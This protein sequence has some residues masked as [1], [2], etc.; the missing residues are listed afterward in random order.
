M[1]DM[2]T[3][4]TNTCGRCKRVSPI[5]FEVEPAEAWR[6]V[7]LNRWRRICPTCFDVEAKKAGVRYKF[8][9]L[10]GTNWSDVPAPRSRSKRR[11]S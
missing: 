5:E 11:T 6:E 8:A 10:E 1:P 7:V 4:H 2:V 9:R 3:S